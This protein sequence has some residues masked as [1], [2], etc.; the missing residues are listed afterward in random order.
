MC[1]KIDVVKLKVD[2]KHSII[3]M[4]IP[5]HVSI[6]NQLLF[7]TLQTSREPAPQT[8]SLAFE[9]I[10]QLHVFV[11]SRTTS[12]R[13]CTTSRRRIEKKQKR[14]GKLIAYEWLWGDEK[15]TRLSRCFQESYINWL[16]EKWASQGHSRCHG[17][18]ENSWMALRATLLK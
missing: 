4:L 14:D 5:Y 15:Y 18:M 2:M 11:R 16:L 8:N 13:S 17:P 3:Y 12:K 6:R 10:W 9:L 7:I 1:T